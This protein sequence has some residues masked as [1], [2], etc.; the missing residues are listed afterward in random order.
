LQHTLPSSACFLV[1]YRYSACFIWKHL[2]PG[3]RKTV[4]LTIGWEALAYY[5][6]LAHEW[7]AE[8]REFE[9]LVGESSQDKRATSTFAL[10]TTSRF[11][12]FR[13]HENVR[14]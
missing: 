5:D 4:T 7:V 3:E 11:G 2:E 12:G 6:D 10:T 14:T 8:A 1:F 13:E 9:V